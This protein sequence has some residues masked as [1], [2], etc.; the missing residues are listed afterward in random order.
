MYFDRDLLYNLRYTNI[1]L[2]QAMLGSLGSWD[3]KRNSAFLRMF[4]DIVDLT[5]LDEHYNNVGT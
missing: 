4:I 3:A 2:N 1:L 5:G